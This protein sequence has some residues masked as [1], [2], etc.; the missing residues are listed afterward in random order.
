MF[1]TEVGGHETVTFSDGTRIELNTNTVLR[2]RMTTAQRTVWLDKG[3]AY[4]QVK[5][6]PA[7]PLTVIAGH[8]VTD[9]GTEFLVRDDAT[10][11]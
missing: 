1:S 8:R 11:A 9:L 4:F 10:Q 2:A 7:H 5:H 6:D 3:E